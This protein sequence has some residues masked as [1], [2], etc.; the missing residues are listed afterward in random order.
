MKWLEKQLAAYQAGLRRYLMLV[1]LGMLLVTVAAA[2]PPDTPKAK[3]VQAITLKVEGATI[4]LVTAFPLTVTAPEGG[5]LYRWSGTPGLKFVDKRNVCTVISGTKGPHTLTVS[6]VIYD[7]T[8]DPP[9]TEAVGE[10]SFA[11]GGVGPVPPGPTPPDP[12]V[13]PGPTPDPTSPFSGV[14]PPGLRVLIVEETEK[15]TELP[16]GQQAVIRGSVVRDYLRSKT[17]LSPDGKTREW[18]ILDQNDDVTGLPKH[19][20]DAMKMKRD[21][22]PWLYVGNSKTGK[23]MPLPKN[24]DEMMK[25]LKEHGG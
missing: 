19:W 22:L 12:P 11:V 16:I 17:V 4:T 25:I 3:P 6:Y 10:T 9:I 21:S 14:E 15:R 5:F 2:A 7:K 18:W 20:Q 8:K 1:G 23:S 13:P 24:V